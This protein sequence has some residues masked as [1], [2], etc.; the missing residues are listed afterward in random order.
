M[1]KIKCPQCDVSLNLPDSAQGKTLRC[2]KCKFTFSFGNPP[3]EEPVAEVIV[4]SPSM[5][6]PLPQVSPPTARHASTRQHSGWL[7]VAKRYG[8]AAVLVAALLYM[9]ITGDHPWSDKYEVP[10]PKGYATKD[11]VRKAFEGWIASNGG[12]VVMKKKPGGRYDYP[13]YLFR[14]MYDANGVANTGP[15]YDDY[16]TL[17]TVLDMNKFHFT[18]GSFAESLPVFL[19]IASFVLFLVPRNKEPRN[20]RTAYIL[21]LIGCLGCLGLHRHYCRKY[22]SAVGQLFT[23]GGFFVWAFKDLGRIPQLVWEANLSPE[24]RAALE[25]QRAQQQANQSAS[26]SSGT[27]PSLTTK[28]GIAYGIVKTNQFLE[29]ERDKAKAIREQT[30]ELKRQRR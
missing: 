1:M 12:V 28:I 19:L 16:E 27:S 23:L 15:E 20:T 30:E 17:E 6:V 9:G 29:A 25:G 2:P 3:E 26:A 7:W 5:I 18:D 11:G 4:E 21:W 14:P 10:L 8:W 22:A 24:E 13:N